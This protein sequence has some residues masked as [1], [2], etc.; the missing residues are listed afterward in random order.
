VNSNPTYPRLKMEY[1]LEKIKQ[2]SKLLAEIVE[3]AIRTKGQDE[4]LIG[5]MEMA[6]QE[7]LLKIGNRA[8]QCFLEKADEETEIECKCG[9]K[10]KYQRRRKAL[11]VSLEEVIAREAE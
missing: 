10:L 2:I 6:M 11:N 4:V 8:V 7:S 9:D 5:D 1:N 3:E